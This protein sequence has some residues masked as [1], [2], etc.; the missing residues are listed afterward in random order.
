MFAINTELQNLIQ[1]KKEEKEAA[2]M[3]FIQM[4][5]G[6]SMIT[7]GLVYAP[8]ESQVTGRNVIGPTPHW[9][10][11]SLVRHIGFTGPTPRW[12]DTSLVRHLIGPTLRW[13]DTSL[14]R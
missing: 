14:V 8:Q 1:I 6:K 4:I 13:S 7:M 5:C 12:S 2:E 11:T 9:S 10:D 3:M